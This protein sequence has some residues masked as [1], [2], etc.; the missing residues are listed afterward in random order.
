[1]ISPLTSVSCTTLPIR[2]LLFYNSS[3]ICHSWSSIH[4]PT[5][6]FLGCR[7]NIGPF[8]HIKSCR[9]LQQIFYG[10]TDVVVRRL[11]SDL[12]ADLEQEEVR[13]YH[14]CAEGSA[15]LASHPSAYQL[16]DRGLRLQRPLWSRFDILQPHLQSCPGG[17]RQ[18][19]PAICS[20]RRP[21]CASNQDPSLW[22]QK[23]LCLL[24]G[25][26]ELTREDIRIPEL[27]LERFKSMLETHF[28]LT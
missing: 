6:T 26:L 12:N 27:S 5:I 20:S 24:T 8:P 4:N 2:V 11:Q 17:W 25:C 1:M 7:E 19:S 28:L 18:A 3:F 22:A 21:D 14:F 13:P 10:A 9:L 15:P 23:L 16:Q